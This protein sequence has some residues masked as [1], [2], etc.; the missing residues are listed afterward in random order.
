MLSSVFLNCLIPE[1]VMNSGSLL[2][3]LYGVQMQQNT[4]ENC[5]PWIAISVTFLLH[6]YTIIV[7]LQMVSSSIKVRSSGSNFTHLL[8]HLRNLRDLLVQAH[9]VAFGVDGDAGEKTHQ[10]TRQEPENTQA[11]PFHHLTMTMIASVKGFW[12]WISSPSQ[13]CAQRRRWWKSWKLPP[14]SPGG[15]NESDDLDSW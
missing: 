10:K 12:I 3:E 7:K 11:I 13:R 5:T 8:T 15:D 9:D 2:S 4:K 6:N 1:I 14:K